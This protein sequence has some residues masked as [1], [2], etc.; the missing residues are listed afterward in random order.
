MEEQRQ[1]CDYNSQVVGSCSLTVRVEVFKSG[2][3][4][5][6]CTC[7]PFISVLDCLLPA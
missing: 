5:I 1:F 3:R 4:A 2:V 7:E 6:V